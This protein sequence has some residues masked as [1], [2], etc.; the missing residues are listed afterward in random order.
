M[1]RAAAVLSFLIVSL[2]S[3]CASTKKV[4]FVDAAGVPVDNCSVF[5]RQENMLYP[6]STDFFMT[7]K[8]GVV[9][10]SR[11]GLL[12]FYAGK[13]GYFISSFA[14]VGAADVRC[15]LHPLNDRKPTRHLP[16]F[17]IPQRELMETAKDRPE[18]KTWIAYAASAPVVE[19]SEQLKKNR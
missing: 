5:V 8:D 13:E 18:A 12:R 15:V 14:L 11:V 1:N 10:I 6:N 17:S 19:V 9:T 4:I 7:G 3:G 2:L 16:R